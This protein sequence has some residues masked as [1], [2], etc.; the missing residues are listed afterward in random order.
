VI[1]SFLQLRRIFQD[2]LFRLFVFLMFGYEVAC[3]HK[4][5]ATEENHG[6]VC[7]IGGTWSLFAEEEFVV[8]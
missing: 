4:L 5:E 7:V 6:E 1:S 8:V 2:A 3:S